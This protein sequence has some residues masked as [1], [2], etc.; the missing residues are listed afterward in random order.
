MMSVFITWPPAPHR[1]WTVLVLILSLRSGLCDVQQ[2]ESTSGVKPSSLDGDDA[3]NAVTW[4]PTT[5]L[6]NSDVDFE[7]S[8]PSVVR[9]AVGT[10]TYLTCRPRA[11]RNKTVSWIRH[12]DLHILTMGRH[13]YTKDGRFSVFHQRHTSE[14][15]LQLRSAQLRD[16]GLYECQIGTQPTRSFFVNLTVVE[17]TSSIFGGPDIHVHQGSSVNIS[18]IVQNAAGQ[19][20]YFFWFR[21]RQLVDFGGQIEERRQYFA[22]TDVTVSS[23]LIEQAHLGHS[24]NY[25]CQPAHCPPSSARIHILKGE[26][27]AAMQRS[28][29]TM[30]ASDAALRWRILSVAITFHLCYFHVL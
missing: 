29:S 26:Q 21:N 5:P 6:T 20:E 28:S 17:P 2:E 15:T 30:D 14:W 3:K 9:V 8:V 22:D 1:L 4:P 7:T 12:R 11:L 16:S 10:T 13:M 24:G 25:T 19:P 18:C 27:P 23:L